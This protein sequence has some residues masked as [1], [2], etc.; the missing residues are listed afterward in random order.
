MI[1]RRALGVDAHPTGRTVQTCHCAKPFPLGK[2]IKDDMIADRRELFDLLI[3]IGGLKDVVFFAHLLLRETRFIDAACCRPCQ[4]APNQRIV[5]IH[6]ET[7]LREEDRCS[8]ILCDLGKDFEVLLQKLLID[9]I[10]RRRNLVPLRT[11][12]IRRHQ[13]TSTGSWLSCH[14]SPHRFSA[15]MNGSGSNSST[16][17]TP[18]FRHFPVMTIIAPI[19]AGTPVV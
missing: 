11:P 15:S 5:V 17:K 18:G 13:S 2:R 19:I 7:L 14:G 16:L 3:L 9:E 8:R 12:C 10:G 1:L 4:I 6:G